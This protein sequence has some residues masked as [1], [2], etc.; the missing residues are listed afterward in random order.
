MSPRRRNRP[1]GP[2]ES[3]RLADELSRQILSG[4]LQPGTPLREE[5]L[6]EQSGLSRHTVRTA[7][8]RLSAERLVTQRP[9]Q[10]IRVRTFSAG[11]LLALQQLRCALEVEAV[12]LV[13]KRHGS[14]WPTT[15]LAPIEHALDELER[16]AAAC[17]NDWPALAAAHAAVHRAVVS[18]A[19][20]PRIE[21]AYALLDSEM[22]LLLVHMRPSYSARDLVEEHR[23]YLRAVMTDGER[24]ARRH[25]E[26]GTTQIRP[27]EQDTT[28]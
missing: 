18:A 4:E 2:T 15:V 25:I 20:S 17:P 3:A 22:L 6:A 26:H 11:D 7:L 8:A 13:R 14:A 1:A 12:R 5:S 24:A 23:S 21:Q 16:V 9:Y 28:T 27:R 19:A 10:G